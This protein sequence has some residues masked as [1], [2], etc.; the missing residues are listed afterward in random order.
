[1]GT[2]SSKEWNGVTRKL[3]LATLR[4]LGSLGIRIADK[5]SAGDYKGA[6]ST[7]IDHRNYG[8]GIGE[9]YRFAADYLASSLVR[10]LDC[11]PTGVD[12]AAVAREKWLDSEATCKVMN[13]CGRVWT[14]IAPIGAP[15]EAIISIARV[16]MAKLLR[17]LDLNEIYD[18]MSFSGG[19]ST[20]LKRD[21]GHPYYKF[22]GKPEVTREA[23]LPAVACIWA[24]PVW[25]E[26]CKETFGR[27]SDPTT[28]VTVVPGS[29]FSTVPKD[30]RT[31][32][33]VIFE[34]ELNML[35]QKGSGSVIRRRLLQAGIDLRDQS[36]NQQLAY[37]GSCTG[38]LATVDLSS[39]SDS[40]SCR[41][42][43]ELLPPD[44]FQWLDRI[45]SHRVSLDGRNGKTWHELEK[46]SSMG[47]GFTFELESAIF[48]CLSQAVL[49]YLGTEDKRLGIY[50]DDIVIHHSAVPLLNDVFTYVGFSFNSEKS[51]WKGPFR[52]SCGKH[53]YLGQDV[54]P[55]FVKHSLET[56]DQLYWFANSLRAW[57]LRVGDYRLESLY[58]YAVTR[59]PC[60]RRIKIPE[61]LGLKAGLHATF[62]EA[63]PAYCK[64]MQMFR[65]N[66][67]VPRRRKH[68]ISGFP[69]YLAV[70][71]LPSSDSDGSKRDIIEKGA[72]VWRQSRRYIAVWE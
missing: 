2:T 44:W 18:A 43:R 1:M 66:V 58:K 30:A 57:R 13:L 29:C 23:A 53:Y 37:I 14:P 55:F 5:I 62:D 34:P 25:R 3:T 7:S 22:Q 24:S 65:I 49:D 12:T 41:I 47:N 59:I 6:I 26:Y 36:R 70:L 40:I 69:A 50:G 54:T 52:E 64:K 20:R 28:W 16:K 60:N 4:E 11:L 45:R 38:S 31:D 35:M 15:Q 32:R 72:V 67:L 42:V 27:D 68:G 10:K 48:F 17:K 33:P 46:F 19:A 61:S 9:S 8:Y 63:R 56:L 21:V 71:Q 51:F 39:A